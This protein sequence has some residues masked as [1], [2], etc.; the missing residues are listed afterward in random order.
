MDF[1]AGRLRVDGWMKGFPTVRSLSVKPFPPLTSVKCRGD[2][3]LDMLVHSDMAGVDTGVPAG[4]SQDRPTTAVLV[5]S[6]ARVCKRKAKLVWLPSLLCPA[7]L[8][9]FKPPLRAKLRGFAQAARQQ[10]RKRTVQVCKTG[11]SDVAVAVG[12]RPRF[13]QLAS[14]DSY[15]LEVRYFPCASKSPSDMS[16]FCLCL[17][18][19]PG[20]CPNPLREDSWSTHPGLALNRFASATVLVFDAV[21]ACFASRHLQYHQPL[22]DRTP[23]RNYPRHI[24]G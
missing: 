14:D 15:C 8:S 7:C 21:S 22:T 24:A 3:T 5:R 16:T 9:C 19:I 6:A 4:Y 17:P 2:V 23:T 11:P 20:P 13:V 12:A 10:R 18:Q 1:R